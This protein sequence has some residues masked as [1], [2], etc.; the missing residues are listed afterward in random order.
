MW[1]S[2]HAASFGMGC[3]ERQAVCDPEEAR[4][5]FEQ[6]L[7]AGMFKSALENPD[8]EVRGMALVHLHAFEAEGDRYSR[9]ILAAWRAKHPAR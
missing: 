7:D 8:D 2:D 3:R 4:A 5:L 6:F 1:F 9:G